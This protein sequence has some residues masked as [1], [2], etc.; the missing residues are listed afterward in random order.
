MSIRDHVR[1]RDRW[2]ARVRVVDH[3]VIFKALSAAE[4]DAYV[5]SGEGMG[6]AGGYAIQGRAETF[7]RAIREP[8]ERRRLADCSKPARC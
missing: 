3:I 7:V 2:Q 8:F 5:E 4:I 1:R 6:K